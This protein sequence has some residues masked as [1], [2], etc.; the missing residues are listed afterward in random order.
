M[1]IVIYEPLTVLL[2]EDSRDDEQLA[3]RALRQCGLPLFVRVARDGEEALQV[4]GLAGPSP[5]SEQIP[6]LVISDL[7]MPKLSGE[8]VLRR[9]RADER[10]RH[11]P[12]VLLSSSDETAD[13]HQCLELGASAYCA[14]PVG[15]PEFIECVAG[16]ARHW[17]LPEGTARVP[18]CILATSEANPARSCEV[19]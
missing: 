5:G 11:V 1:P 18:F 17:L 2:F 14:K 12:Y 7:K 15:Y 13:V 10:L 6:D 9:A 3:L 8:E 16:I 19:R 4:L